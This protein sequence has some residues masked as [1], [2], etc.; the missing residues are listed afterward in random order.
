VDQDGDLDLYVCNYVKYDPDNPI[1]CF[2]ADGKPGICHPD[3]VDPEPDVLFVNLGDGTFQ[4]ILAEAGLDAPGSKSLGVAIADFNEDQLADIFVANDTTANHLFINE[5]KLKF[6]ETGLQAGVATNGDGL[7]Q[8]SMGV[9][10]GDYNRDG[11]LDLYL[12]H[13]T[14][15]SNT[16]YRGL[17]GGMFIDVTQELGLHLPT[18]RYLAFGTVMADFDCNGREDFFVANG[19]IDDAFQRQGDAFK[20]PAQLFTWTGSRFRECTSTGGPYFERKLLGRGVAAGDFD[21]DGDVDLAV[22]HQLDDASILRND[23]HEGHWLKLKF[24]GTKSNRNGVGVKVWVTQAGQRMYNQL[25]GGTSYC[26]AHEPALFFGLGQSDADV[27]IEVVW[28][29]GRKSSLPKAS[30][31]QMLVIQEPRQDP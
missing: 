16:L 23:C 4:G 13:F 6:R 18:L 22:S 20:M 17:G 3:E 14:S 31:D 2:G 15:D 24:V 21:N 12:T 11:H 26:A 9:G 27:G 1:K 8:A 10:F 7:F 30:V 25:A 5:G 29:S 19:H 28:P